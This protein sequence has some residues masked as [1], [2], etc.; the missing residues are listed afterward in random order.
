MTPRPALEEYAREQVERLKRLFDGV[1][2]CRIVLEPR[3]NALRAVIELT[4]P[5][6]RLVSAHQSDPESLALDAARPADPEAQ[7]Q[8]VLHEAFAAARRTLRD[9]VVRRRTLARRPRSPALR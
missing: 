9:Y 6:D 8:H 2:D 1:V 7:W 3:D 4:V 5:G